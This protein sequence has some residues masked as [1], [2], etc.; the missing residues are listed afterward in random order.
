MKTRATRSAIYYPVDLSSKRPRSVEPS[1]G[2]EQGRVDLARVQDV[3]EHRPRQNVQVGT[4][5]HYSHSGS[6]PLV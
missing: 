3:L 4:L 1:V 2:L 5:L 6:H